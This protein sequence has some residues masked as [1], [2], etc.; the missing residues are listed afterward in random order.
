M[1]FEIVNNSSKACGPLYHWSGSLIKY[2]LI[3]KN[4]KPLRDEVAAL[5]QKS[6]ELDV[7]RQ[8]AIK[9]VAE[10]EN[11]IKQFK[12]DYAIAIRDTEQIRKEMEEVTKKV[13]RAS[14]LLGSLEEEKVR[15]AATSQS[16][17]DQMSTLIGDNLIAAGFLTYGGIFDQKIRKRLTMEWSDTLENLGIPFKPDM[18]I[19]PYLST[20]TEHLQW[21]DW[22][23]PID[24]L[25]LQ[26][27]IL[28]QRFNRYPLIVDPSGQATNFITNKYAGKKMLVTSFID[29]AFMKTLASAVRF[30]TPLMVQDV[31]TIDP[32]LNPILN[33]EFQKTGGRTLVHIGNEAIDFT[34]SFVVFLITRNPFARFS[35]DL[36]SRV[37]MINF[38]VTPNSLQSQALSA[39]LKAE[40]PD[41]DS[42]R[43]EVL[44]MQGE[45][46]AKMKDLEDQLLNKIS[47]V[48]GNI[49]DDDSVIKTLEFIKGEAKQLNLAIEKTKEI[50]EEVKVVSNLYVPLAQVM[51]AVYFSLEGLSDIYFLYQYSLQFLF[52]VMEKVLNA[53]K[54]AGGPNTD[55]ASAK[56]RLKFLKLSFFTEITRRVL[57]GLKF[58]DKL[59]FIVRLAQISTLENQQMQLTDPE[60]DLLLKGELNYFISKLSI[61]VRFIMSIF[62][63]IITF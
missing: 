13:A 28:L 3:L 45:Q 4:I 16:F 30:G 22:G 11:M 19:I 43:N 15:W 55:L 33:K 32:V 31:E 57:R 40:R 24:E 51:T 44:K 2:A 10:L 56:E 14:A 34:V 42:R 12:T 60:I 6:E 62:I 21:R 26:N 50:L 25:A 54:T 23:L 58:E 27:A 7:G 17:D 8:E 38:T 37:T 61:V 18:E 48:Q 59:M 35:P 41:V 20:S 29:A 49:L 1:N 47:A 53:S 39:V 46:A 63:M 52:E 5:V 9:N 36:C